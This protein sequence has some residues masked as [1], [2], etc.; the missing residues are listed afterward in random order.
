MDETKNNQTFFFLATPAGTGAVGV[1]QFYGAEEELVELLDKKIVIPGKNNI[2]ITLMLHEI[3]Y[4]WLVGDGN[5]R[6]DEVL[7]AKPSEGSRTLMG[8]GGFFITNRICEYYRK[9]GVRYLNP[10]EAFASEPPWDSRDAVIDTLL[11]GCLTET[12]V[13]HILAVREARNRGERHAVFSKNLLAMHRVCLAGPPN[14]GKSSLLNR[15]SGFTRA[16]VHAEAGATRDVV[17]DIV[18]LAG[19]TAIVEDL[20]G[21]DQSG[22]PIARA[23]WTRAADRVRRA[24]V[25]AF[26]FDSH[27]GWDETTNNAAHEIKRIIEEPGEG[28]DCRRARPRILIV[29]NKSDLSDAVAGA[30]WEPFFPGAAAVRVSA[31]EGGDAAEKFAEAV[32]GLLL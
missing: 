20:P 11:A 29:Q 2:R 9:L 10:E 24:E 32:C 7:L 1:F 25:I 27:A 16:L 13:A 12:Q 30:P 8:H 18:E 3:G 26:V 15:L 17:N 28:D 23:A 19:Y 5:M 31:L 21:F 4:G 14:V 22:Y 6:L